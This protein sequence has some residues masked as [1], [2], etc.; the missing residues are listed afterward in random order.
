MTPRFLL[1]NKP[2]FILELLKRV[3]L[4]IIKTYKKLV[5]DTML[6]GDVIPG[7]PPQRKT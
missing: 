3:L 7:N 5:Y 2:L 1:E 6:L 4:Y